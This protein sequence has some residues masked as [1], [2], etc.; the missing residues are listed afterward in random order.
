MSRARILGLVAALLAIPFG[1]AA[2]RASTPSP[3]V[4][5]AD[6][7]PSVSGD[8]YRLDPNGH[9][10]NLTQSPDQ[11]TRPLVSP[12][13]K[14]VAFLS[15]HED[16]VSVYEVGI[17]GHG[18]VRVGPTLAQQGQY[19][20][21][22]WQPNG[23]RVALTG[24]ATS[25][26]TLHTSLWILRRGHKP[27][28]VA[29]AADATAPSWSA[30]GRVLLV[31][32]YSTRSATAFSPSGRKLFTLH[33]ASVFSSWSANGLLAVAGK[34]GVAVY[35]ET[36]HRHFTASGA[37]EGGPVWSPNG[38]LLAAVAGHK[39]DVLGQAGSRVLQKSLAGRHGL[40][41]SGDG[42]LVLGGY[43]SCGCQ[44]KAVDIRTGTISPASARWFDPLSASRKLAAV[45]SKSAGG[46][47]IRVAPTAGGA[48]RTYGRVPDC[49]SYGAPIPAASS[50][51]FAGRTRSLVYQSWGDC[52]EPFANL[53]SAAPAG[54]SVQRL[55]NDQAQETQPARSPDGTE[56]AYVWARATGLSC[57]GCSD[58]IRIASADGA[59]IRTLTDPQDCTFDDSPTWSP[60]G[61]TILYSETTCNTGGELFTMPAT[62][63]AAKDLGIAGTTP[64][65][66]P[67]R[68]AYVGSDQSDGGLWTADPDGSNRVLVA[69]KGTMPAWS[70]TGR[71][72]YFTG[73]LYHR[74]LVIGSSQVTL[75]FA[76]ISS[77]AWTPDGT[78]LVVTAST[79]KFG[80]SDLYTVATDGTDPVRL[81]TNYE[82]S[83]SYFGP[84]G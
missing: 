54:G 75:P 1:A 47:A 76:R 33:G 12:D 60:D 26:S 81:T 55:T 30:D 50:L 23:S 46:Y 41:W 49:L 72:A 7:A 80:V 29:D 36:G 4:F 83:S 24:S 8:V 78:R 32:S 44:A 22:A 48:G 77:L 63:G 10:V 11:D 20:Y 61:A 3:I 19:P 39:L 82:V 74:T 73:D 45:T 37:V 69:A 14:T 42:R 51:Q 65:W 9:L 59:P 84:G 38:Q 18:L 43:G 67:T 79:T 5:A 28:R 66:G 6:R 70:S 64:A 57:A 2:S 16:S 27:I 31:F 21:L 62:G 58:G 13:G 71:L 25:G 52:D 68:I 17:D 53:Y 40:V 56:I 34:S 15:Q 35:D